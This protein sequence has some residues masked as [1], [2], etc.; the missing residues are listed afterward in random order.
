MS[1]NNRNALETRLKIEGAHPE[2]WIR[3]PLATR[4]RKWELVIGRGDTTFYDDF[5]SMAHA[6]ADRFDDLGAW[7]D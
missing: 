6:L 5:W 7:I 1:D 3:S 4:S 2:I